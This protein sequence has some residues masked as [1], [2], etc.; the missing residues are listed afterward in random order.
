MYKHVQTTMALIAPGSNRDNPLFYV[1]Y[2]CPQARADP[3][4]RGWSGG[5]KVN[6]ISII[7]GAASAPV[8]TGKYLRK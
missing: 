7:Y 1:G 3:E 4:V 6:I 8:G 5:F 2:C